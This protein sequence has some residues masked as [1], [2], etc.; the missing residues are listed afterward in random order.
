V[1]CCPSL[2]YCTED[3]PV[4]VSPDVDG[5]YTPPVGWDGTPPY[6]TE[7]EALAA[8]PVFPPEGEG[9]FAC[10]PGESAATLTATISGGEGSHTLAWNVASWQSAAFG[11]SC[12]A[13][14]FVLNFS[15]ACELTWSN[16]GGE[17]FS[18]IVPA[19]STSC[20]P[21]LSST[22]W[23]FAPGGTCGTLTVSVDE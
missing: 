17:T 19:G 22:G 18:G 2:W 23:G 7:A 4:E 21:P 16:D 8:C 1:A 5:I 6:L 14:S 3:G 12:V 9:E 20:G 15:Q 11:L 10:C 13:G